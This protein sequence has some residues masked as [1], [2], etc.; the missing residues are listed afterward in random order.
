VWCLGPDCFEGC[1]PSEAA[2]FWKTT[3]KN[4][5]VLCGIVHN[6]SFRKLISDV[7]PKLQVPCHTMYSDFFIKFTV[8]RHLGLDVAG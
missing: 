4:L 2:L 5:I 8:F 1:C 7:N 6:V 3:V